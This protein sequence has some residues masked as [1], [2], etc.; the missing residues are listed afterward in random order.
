MATKL[1]LYQLTSEPL[2][3]PTEKISIRSSFFF[4]SSP[5]RNKF[6]LDRKQLSVPKPEVEIISTCYLITLFPIQYIYCV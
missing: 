5:Q 1:P 6:L 2:N 3:Y 4:N